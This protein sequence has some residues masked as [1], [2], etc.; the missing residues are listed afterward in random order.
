LSQVILSV[1]LPLVSIVT[2][3]YN[4]ASFIKETIDSVIN[5][6]Y[7]QW[8][9]IIVDD[10]STDNSVAVINDTLFDKRI[11]LII[12]QTNKGGNFCRNIGIREAKGD[13]V[14]FLD[15]D[16]LLTNNCIEDRV[17]HA[18][19]NPQSNL[20]VF[21]MGV[22]FSKIGDSNQ[23]WIPSSANPLKDILQHNLPWS[24]LQPLWKREFLLQLNGFDESFQR[25]QDVDLN[26]R[27]LIHASVNYK[28]IPETID[29]YY[30]I[31]EGRKNFNTFAFLSRWVD[32]AVTYCD[33][34]NLLLG[35]NLKK[36]LLG[37]LYQT[38]FHV[39]YHFK[40][41]E[42]SK[43]EFLTLEKNI[44]GHALLQS[45]NFKTK[46]LFALSKYYNLYFFRVPGLN[47]II[48]YLLTL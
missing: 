34:M 9:L 24:I 11:K 27:A 32:S 45:V 21:S 29:C 33:K 10:C 39:L 20:L 25:L 41:K 22:F 13:Y 26:T 38:Y 19:K 3:C 28:L 14:I 1:L 2:A 8:E 12:S 16:D 17:Y 40:R 43:E 7:N 15:A 5:Q 42:I 44:L 46:K 31:D 48:K 37:T 18:H 36:Y 47:R 6:T 30:R 23:K 4:K 35:V